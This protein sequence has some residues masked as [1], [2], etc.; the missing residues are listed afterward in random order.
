[1]REGA[2]PAGQARDARSGVSTLALVTCE[3]ALQDRP[4]MRAA[5][6]AR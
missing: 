1:M 6:L 5:A 4:V 2:L 3:G